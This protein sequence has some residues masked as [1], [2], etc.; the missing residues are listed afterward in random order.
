MKVYLALIIFN[1]VIFIQFGDLEINIPSKIK[2]TSNVTANVRAMV[3][4]VGNTECIT[5][6]SVSS[7]SK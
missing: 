1:F 7:R 2:K 3:A 5:L 6:A 4:N